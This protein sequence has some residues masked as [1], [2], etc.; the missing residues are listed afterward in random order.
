MSSGYIH[1][2]LSRYQYVSLYIYIAIYLFI[3]ISVNSLFNLFM[4]FC[5]SSY[6]VHLSIHLF[7]NSSKFAN[8]LCKSQQLK[9][10][11]LYS[12]D[13]MYCIYLIIQSYL[14]ICTPICLYSVH[15]SID[16]YTYFSDHPSMYT[17]I[18]LCMHLSI[19]EYIYLSMYIVYIYLS[20]N[21]S[22]STYLS[23]FVPIFL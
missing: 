23:I 21:L 6:I 14:Y 20:I 8:H 15:L 18:Y 22:V 5:L 3:Y 2:Y 17:S 16:L 7:I 12:Y 13:Y 10:S 19:Y 9:I 1:F 11:N 4:F